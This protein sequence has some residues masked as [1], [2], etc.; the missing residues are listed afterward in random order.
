MQRT[1]GAR[2]VNIEYIFYVSFLHIFFHAIINFYSLIYINGYGYN[3]SS[4][5][6]CEY[7]IFL[8]EKQIFIFLILLS[9]NPLVPSAANMRRNA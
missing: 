7:I 2:I 3:N 9:F 5:E 6:K 1:S 4:H 8:Q